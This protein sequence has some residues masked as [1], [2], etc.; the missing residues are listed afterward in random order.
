MGLEREWAHSPEEKYLK[1]EEER[2]EPSY[3]LDIQAC[4]RYY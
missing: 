4:M 2:Q 3:L 1:G